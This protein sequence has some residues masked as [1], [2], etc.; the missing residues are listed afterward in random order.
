M[1]TV[2]LCL[3]VEVGSRIQRAELAGFSLE[4]YHILCT[5]GSEREH[6]LVDVLREVGF[7]QNDLARTL[8]F[9]PPERQRSQV[10][11]FPGTSIC[12]NLEQG[13]TPVQQTPGPPSPSGSEPFLLL[14]LRPQGHMLNG[15]GVRGP[16]DA[17]RDRQAKRRPPGDRRRFVHPTAVRSRNHV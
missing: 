5:H 1:D 15:Q 4:T 7:Y 6:G 14:H 2:I 10:E 8:A 16:D 17:R 11:W 12:P 3:E 9:S 13:H